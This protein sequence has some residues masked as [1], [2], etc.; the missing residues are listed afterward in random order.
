[1]LFTYSF[2]VM[3]N[4]SLLISYHEL[5]L[6][7]SIKLGEPKLS[8]NSCCLLNVTWQEGEH[9]QSILAVSNG[10]KDLFFLEPNA[11][12]FIAVCTYI[13][14]LCTSIP[15]IISIVDHILGFLFWSL[16]AEEFHMN[17]LLQPEWQWTSGILTVCLNVQL[18]ISGQL[19]WCYSSSSVLVIIRLSQP[20][21]WAVWC[22][23]CRRKELLMTIIWAVTPC[24]LNCL[25]PLLCCRVEKRALAG[26]LDLTDNTTMIHCSFC[27]ITFKELDSYLR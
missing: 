5:L 20:L 23:L 14:T 17:I 22:P 11:F 16:S 27:R 10:L 26:R 12:F 24:A 21:I 13:C 8:Q 1:M 7:G 25:E 3:L 4:P 9:L 6:D 19:Q 15:I 18:I 2:V